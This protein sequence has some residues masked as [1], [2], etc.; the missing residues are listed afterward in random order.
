MPNKDKRSRLEKLLSVLE[1]STN[2]DTLRF[3]SQKIANVGLQHPEHL[4]SVLRQIHQVL[5]SRKWE[6]RVYA[7]EA[8]AE[9]ASRIS[10]PSREEIAEQM[11]K[12]APCS[13]SQ[14]LYDFK[15]DTI[16]SVR[17]PLLSSGDQVCEPYKLSFE[18]VRQ[19]LDSIK[20]EFLLEPPTKDVGRKQQ[21]PK[22]TPQQRRCLKRTRTQIKDSPESSSSGGKPASPTATKD[23]G[24]SARERNKNK[25]QARALERADSGVIDAAMLGNLQRQ[26][27][28]RMPAVQVQGE[29]A[30]ADDERES[31]RIAAG[32]WPFQR[33]ADQLLLHLLDSSWNVRH[34]AA[35]GLRQLL[36]SH[37]PCAA[38]AFKPG[39]PHSGWRVSGQSGLMQ[40]Q[41][42][43]EEE[44][45]AAV[46]AHISWLQDTVAFL[47]FLLV[48]DRFAD[49]HNDAATA[50]VR[51]TA[52]QALAYAVAALPPSAQTRV[53]D[54]LSSMQP[55]DIWEVRQG[56][57]LGIKY[58][59]AVCASLAPGMAE[60]ALPVLLTAMEDGDDDVRSAAVHACVP[61]AHDIAAQPADVLHDICGRLWA[62]LPS[63]DEVSPAPA[64]VMQLL[65]LLCSQ[66]CT[67][68]RGVA[69]D[70]AGQGRASP[71]EDDA[72]DTM[73]EMP[74]VKA[75]CE[76]KKLAC[77]ALDESAG[78]NG[79]EVSRPSAVDLLSD[80]EE[81]LPSLWP[82]FGHSSLDVQHACATCCLKLARCLL[83]RPRCSPTT[84][85]ALRVML[86][87][88][89]QLMFTTTDLRVR[90]A[91]E[92]LLMVLLTAAQREVLAAMLDAETLYALMELPCTAVG[93]LLP[94]QRLVHYR[95][96]Q[97][98]GLGR[99]SSRAS[100]SGDLDMAGAL[101]TFKNGDQD[102][103]HMEE[104]VAERRVACARL[105]GCAA[106]VV[107]H[108]GVEADPSPVAQLAAANMR[109]LLAT[110]IYSMKSSQCSYGALVAMFW[111]RQHPVPRDAVPA[112]VR[113]PVFAAL[114]RAPMMPMQELERAQQAVQGCLARVFE[115]YRNAGAP[116]QL[117]DGFSIASVSVQYAGDIL[118]SLDAAQSPCAESQRLATRDSI[119]MFLS[120]EQHMRL[121][122]S[123]SVAAAC[124]AWSDLPEK[125]NSLVKPL[126]AALRL[127]S[128]PAL[129]KK[130]VAEALAHLIIV[131]IQ[132]KP[133]AIPKILKHLH[134]F[135]CV[136]LEREAD[137][138]TAG[139]A[140]A[141]PAAPAA[142]GDS[143][144][145]RGAEAALQQLGR[146]L[147]GG[148]PASLPQLW[149]MATE[150]ITRCA[151]AAATGPVTPEAV[152]EAAGALRLLHVMAPALERT[153]HVQLAAMVPRMALCYVQATPLLERSMSSA[154]VHLV[155][156]MPDVHLDPIVAA[157]LPCLE[158]TASTGE[159]RAA[160]SLL[161]DLLS[162]NDKLTLA[163]LPYTGLLTVPAMGL[164][165]DANACVRNTASAAFGALVS[166]LPMS[167]NLPPPKLAGL[168]PALRA[169]RCD[170]QAFLEQLLDLHAVADFVPPVLPDGVT[171][172][173][174]QRDGVSWLAFLQRFGLQGILADDMGLGK[175]VQTLT[176]IAAAMHAAK[177][178]KNAGRQPPALPSLIV[179]PTTLV[180]HWVAE[181]AK[182]FGYQGMKTVKYQG[183]LEA[184]QAVQR[185]SRWG[186]DTLVVT[187]YESVRSDITWLSQ[188]PFLYCVLDEG[189]IIRNGKTKV[190]KAC[191]QINARHRL[192]LSGTPIQNNVT[193]LWSI[194]DFLMPGYLGT[195]AE[196][197]CKYRRAATMPRDA[198]HGR[199]TKE[200]RRGPQLDVLDS[201]HKQIL[202]FVLRRTKE[203][204]LDDLP[205][206]VLQDIVCEL[207]PLQQMLYEAEVSHSGLD[208][209][210][211]N[212][213]ASDRKQA[214]EGQLTRLMSLLKLCSHPR[215]VLN[216]ADEVHATAVRTCLPDVDAS[217]PDA[218]DHELMQID[219]A[220]KML[221]FKQLLANMGIVRTAGGAAGSS[222][223]D[224][225]GN[226]GAGE[227]SQHRVL[228]FAQLRSTLDLVEALVLE[229]EGVSYVRLD[230]LV[231][232]LRR[233]EVVQQFN[234]DPSVDVMLLT[235]SI[236]AFGLNLTSADTVVFLEHDWNPMRDLQ[237][238][239]RAHRLG[240]RKMVTVYRLLTKGTLEEYIMNL[241]QFKKDVAGSVVNADNVGMD[242]MDTGAVL[243]LMSGSCLTTATKGASTKNGAV[244]QNGS[245]G[246][247]G[248][249]QIIGQEEDGNF[250]REQQYSEFKIES[251]MDKRG[252]AQGD[253]GH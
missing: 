116:L 128:E 114:D 193:E 183:T 94:Q 131:C 22:G 2:H 96:Q 77:A 241:Q 207:T 119:A 201:L 80:A 157:M 40:R 124:V 154:L 53:Q 60:R 4:S 230:G 172:R 92:E 64:S 212:A 221:A 62:L 246:A 17:R 243:D 159:R 166:I 139:R 165:T 220:P 44:A 27:S 204:V 104:V 178:S 100:A 6:A 137:T 142:T 18:D 227:M 163:L 58:S 35:I 150:P 13:I 81:R 52:A 83:Q 223:M 98:A 110:F 120:Q 179:C 187:S 213:S 90:G 202:P 147:A 197:N 232:P 28:S 33:M 155:L 74:D 217:D 222:G 173:S 153:L 134:G 192:V 99:R 234:T 29:A 30:A 247:D 148:L 198:L 34:G 181:A 174:Y 205:P 186:V 209:S 146:R 233:P 3:A 130:V 162:T 156:A 196:F 252:T 8:L 190:T 203:Q 19:K 49:Y 101:F 185:Q 161:A 31:E 158:A 121:R 249:Q 140:R 108:T 115:E 59:L 149:S 235:T 95:L 9:L 215:M 167:T 117:P 5:Y 141:A 46:T 87:L 109:N 151:A 135:I 36:Q 56:S 238:M 76:D 111:M 132:H 71:K 168:D 189:H 118:D 138:P 10:H 216:M 20:Q 39:S 67:D 84:P 54:V 136:R 69:G 12:P 7:G 51:E 66:P 45:A 57:M 251:F 55:C 152:R 41:P 43:T 82:F 72:E 11:D 97:T 182:W 188:K 89:Y 105:C 21:L 171:L 211:L 48:L 225:D 242:T 107:A 112:C 248:S 113:D 228:C 102:P 208:T 194:F 125:V 37:A 236:G 26:A 219:Q 240:Q 176:V 126:M 164:M 214:S 91:C 1:E 224:G 143:I 75:E 86:R 47:I 16:L 79:V 32:G 38:I 24:Q 237:A 145:E 70:T 210:T 231:P 50:P 244:R 180:G 106:A 61:L 73:L 23:V 229:P 123:A 177:D 129:Q 103:D 170:D 195:E 68:T 245:A 253:Q 184:R 85:A 25:R 93:A 169:K 226:D 250:S 239:D 199:R 160:V 206:K 63:F 88:A 218:V 42:M 133:A 127:V 78:T 191:K 175:T 65:G 122:M 200:K 144:A 15:F 14:S